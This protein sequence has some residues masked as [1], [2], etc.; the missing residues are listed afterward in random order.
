MNSISMLQRS[1]CLLPLALVLPL[2]VACVGPVKQ[3]GDHRPLTE[4]NKGYILVG[5]GPARSQHQAGS[6]NVLYREVPEYATTSL[7]FNKAAGLIKLSVSDYADERGEGELQLVAV[8]AGDYELY[9]VRMFRNQVYSAISE[10]MGK[11]FRVE[12]GKITYLG[13]VHVAAQWKR[14][15]NNDYYPEALSA[16]VVVET[17]QDLERARTKFGETL[18]SVDR[19]KLVADAVLVPF[20]GR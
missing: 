14:Q 5:V 2:L 7:L 8:A 6:Y 17:A 9:Q 19:T 11:R 12:A 4:A 10:P 15:W 13:R 16:Q 18:K 1:K 3:F 20:L